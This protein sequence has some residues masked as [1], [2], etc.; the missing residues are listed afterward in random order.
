MTFYIHRDGQQIG[1]YPDTE[2]QQYFK[3]D[4]LL[5]LVPM[6]FTQKSA[7]DHQPR[8]YTCNATVSPAEFRFDSMAF[9]R[10]AHS[11]SLRVPKP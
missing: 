3:A 5:E 8:H 4:T 6:S 2:V 9:I 10:A 7:Y 11:I 1:P